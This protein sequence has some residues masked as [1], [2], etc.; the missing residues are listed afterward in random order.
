MHKASSGIR[1]TF[2]RWRP[3]ATLC[4]ALPTQAISACHALYAACKLLLNRRNGELA[5]IYYQA[6]VTFYVCYNIFVAWVCVPY[7]ATESKTGSRISVNV[8]IGN[9]TCYL[10][11]ILTFN[12]LFLL[13]FYFSESRPTYCKIN[14][15]N[16]IILLIISNKL[17]VFMLETDNPSRRIMRLLFC[18]SS[19]NTGRT[20]TSTESASRRRI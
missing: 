3:A 8:H 6:F 2:V 11:Y 17:A 20:A 13:K 1:S 5:S 16:L 12:A 10:L 14:L 7:S 18:V 15:R 4:P 9:V 19:I